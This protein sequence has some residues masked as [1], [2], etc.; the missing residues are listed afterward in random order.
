MTNW[1][2]TGTYED[3]SN[4]PAN[5]TFDSTLHLSKAII[6]SFNTDVQLTPGGLMVPAAIWAIDDHIPHVAFRTTHFVEIAHSFERVIET[7]SDSTES[8]KADQL[9]AMIQAID[10]RKT[11]L[12][13]RGA[14]ADPVGKL[15][16]SFGLGKD[17]NLTAKY[18]KATRDMLQGFLCIAAWLTPGASPDLSAAVYALAAFMCL[19]PLPIIRDDV[20][21]LMLKHL[22]T[23]RQVFSRLTR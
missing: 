16:K 3:Y 20:E 21:S 11:Q 1:G 9:K 13:E 7:V 10:S 5:D 2:E 12:L 4:W 22:K 6:Q 14:T 19:G 8:D 18:V 15:F 17:K 23:Q